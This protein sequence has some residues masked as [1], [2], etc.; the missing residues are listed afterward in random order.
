MLQSVTNTDTG[1]YSGM[2]LLE[3]YK[4]YI[5]LILL[6]WGNI[7]T[8][9]GYWEEFSKFLTTFEIESKYTVIYMHDLIDLKELIYMSYGIFYIICV[10]SIG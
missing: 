1:S 3:F 10:P 2:Y 5:S 4:F 8:Y 9:K 6:K 7:M